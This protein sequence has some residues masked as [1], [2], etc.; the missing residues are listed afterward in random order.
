[1]EGYLSI[2]LLSYSISSSALES[3]GLLLSYSIII[4]TITHNHHTNNNTSFHSKYQQS[5]TGTYCLERGV[6]VPVAWENR[7]RANSAVVRRYA[8][9]PLRNWLAQLQQK[10]LRAALKLEVA[11]QRKDCALA[12]AHHNNRKKQLASL[13]S[14]GRSIMAYESLEAHCASLLTSGSGQGSLKAEEV[15]LSAEGL[16]RGNSV[17]LLDF[18]VVGVVRT[19]IREEDGGGVGGGGGGGNFSKGERVKVAVMSVAPEKKQVIL[20]LVERT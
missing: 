3:P 9:Q 14:K 16:G 4:H 7:D 6:N 12:V 18:Q 19:A 20:R 17:K 13:Q 8:T 1:M 10:Q 5:N 15:V 11:L 2:L